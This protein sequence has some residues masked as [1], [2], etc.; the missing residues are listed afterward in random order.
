M[1]SVGW[2]SDCF[3]LGC[4]PQGSY[5]SLGGEPEPVTAGLQMAQ[6]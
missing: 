2:F 3:P 6:R 4:S 5:W 1:V